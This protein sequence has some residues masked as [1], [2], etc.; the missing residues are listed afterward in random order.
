MDAISS[1][2][3]KARRV[4]ALDGMANYQKYQLD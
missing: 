2:S 3:D 4:L 1:I